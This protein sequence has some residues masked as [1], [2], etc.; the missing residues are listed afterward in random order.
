MSEQSID[1]TPAE[2]EENEPVFYNPK[3]LALISNIMEWVAWIVLAG[4]IGHIAAQVVSLNNQ[5]QGASLSDLIAQ[6][7]AAVIFPYLISNMLVPALTGLTFFF[8]LLGVA[9]GLNV[10]REIEFNQR[11]SK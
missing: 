1:P 9:Q 10:L 5:T 3:T 7:G 2:A 4:F 11:E 8:V 6:A